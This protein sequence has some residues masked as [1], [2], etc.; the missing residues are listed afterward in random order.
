MCPNPLSAQPLKTTRKT[1]YGHQYL[2]R[3]LES[4][5]V[6]RALEKNGGDGWTLSDAI[7]PAVRSAGGMILA[8]FMQS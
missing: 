6:G 4:E 2:I 1:T 5:R 8:E 3:T 7:I